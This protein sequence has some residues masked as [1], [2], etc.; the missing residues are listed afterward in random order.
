MRGGPLV[1]PGGLLRRQLPF[2]VA[3]FSRLLI[4]L[5]VRSGV[6]LAEDTDDFL[7]EL[8]HVRAEADALLHGRHAR[9]KLA[10]AH[11]KARGQQALPPSS[12]HSPRHGLASRVAPLTRDL[13]SGWVVQQ[14]DHA[15]AD[16]VQVST[17][18]DQHL[19]G[20]SVALAYEAQQDVFGPDVIMAELQRL[21]QRQL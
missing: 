13:R 10:Q 21:A 15:M 7:I 8:A 5:R 14:T 11:A 18:L 2:R 12:D 17:K 6:L 20:N 16:P 19:G 1:L 4:I 3:Q 9:L